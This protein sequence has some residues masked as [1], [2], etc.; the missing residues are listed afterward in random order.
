[1]VKNIVMV[2]LSSTPKN[3]EYYFRDIKFIK[4]LRTDPR[5]MP[6]FLDQVSNISDDDQI[7]YMSKNSDNYFL[8]YYHGLPVGFGGVINDDIRYAVIPYFQNLGIGTKI[9]N[10]IKIRNPNAKGKIKKDN[11]SSIQAFI[12]ANIPYEVI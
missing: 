9:L 8:A 2:E 11:L 6:G 5:A 1:M 7:A 4:D 12:K 10:Y 3:S